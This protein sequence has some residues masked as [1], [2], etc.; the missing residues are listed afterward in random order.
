MGIMANFITGS[1]SDDNESGKGS[2]FEIGAG[3][4]TPLG[5]KFNFETYGGLGIG[6]ITNEYESDKSKVNFMRF[7][8]QPSI[9][10]SSR[11]FEAIIA[12]RFA[13]L[14]YTSIDHGSGSYDDL[15]FLEDH[16]SSVLF[17]P[18][19]TLRA[20][21]EDFKF[22]LQYVNSN[23]LSHSEIPMEKENVSLGVIIDLNSKK[24]LK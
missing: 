20:G 11:G 6:G 2:M 8:V 22:Q 24:K 9:G 13:H 23:N 5:A 21:W 14:N 12:T 15:Q 18:S 1:G 3:Y 10:Y 16:K 19:I 7:F 17:E 4:F